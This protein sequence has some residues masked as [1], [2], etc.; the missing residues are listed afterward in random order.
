MKLSALTGS[1]LDR[2]MFGRLLLG[3]GVCLTTSGSGARRARAHGQPVYY[4]WEGYDDPSFFVDYVADGRPL[5]IMQTYTDEVEA[6]Q[7]LSAGMPADVSF[8]CADTLPHWREA[9][10]L[11]PIDVSRLSNWPDVI[12]PLRHVPGTETDG[13]QWLAPVEWGTTSVIYR[14]DLV[15][16]EEESYRLLWDPR[17]AGKLAFGED[18][19]ESVIMAALAAGIADPFNMSDDE[20]ALLK[21]QLVAQRDLLKYYWT[22]PAM[23]EQD[24]RSGEIVATSGWSETYLSLKSEGVPVKYMNPREGILSWCCGLALMRSATMIDEAYDLIDAMLGVKA[25]LW[26]TS[27][28][29]VHSNRKVFE[30]GEHNFLAELGLPTD[31]TELLAGSVFLRKSPRL[32][33]YQRMFEEVRGAS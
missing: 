2:R 16:I 7:N 31:P 18:V 32:F 22:E 10:L 24:L 14:T 11:Q 12:E 9:G 27:L 30:A 20:L 33:E 8:P 3:A 6:F 1:L 15:D 29:M 28:G 23:I 26:L 25:G 13:Q 19:T 5:P 21:Q 17:Y 4:T